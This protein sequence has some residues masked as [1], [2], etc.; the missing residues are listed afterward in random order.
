MRRQKHHIQD[1]SAEANLFARR[2][3]VAL[4]VV[5]ALMLVLIANMFYL[6]I[7][8]YQTYQTR[9]N[10]NRIKVQPVPPNRGVI[11][12]INGNILA[13]NE[14]TFSLEVIPEAVDDMDATLDSL[15][16]IIDI[17]DDQIEQ[18]KEVIKYQRRFKSIP[19]KTKLTEQEVAI[20]SVQQHRFPG[21]AIEARL[22]RTY[23]YSDVMTH[24]IG[25]VG[26]INKR[27]LN[28]LEQ[29]DKL[30]NYAA[31]RSIG[32]IGI[33]RFYEDELHGQTGNEEVEVNHRS[34]V[35]RQL[36]IEP[37]KPGNDLQLSI[38]I[39]MQQLAK[40]ALGKN[41]GAIVALDPRDGAI[42]TMYSNPSYD[43]NLFVSGISQKDYSA[44]TS[45]KDKPMLNRATQGQYPPAS[46]VKPQIALLGLEKKLV[47][48]TTT[49][50][51]PG[52]WRFP[53]VE[54][55]RAFRDWKPSGHGW[56]DL[57]HSLVQ[58]CDIYYYDLAYRLGIDEIS[59]FGKKF[60]FGE[61]TGIDIH[62]ESRAIMPSREWKKERTRSPW[63]R[64][65]TISIGIGQGYWTATPTQLA[66]AT[67]VLVNKGE[68]IEP[69]IVTG[70][71]IDG[72]YVN[73]PIKK[74]API[75]LSDPNYWDIILDGLY[76]TVNSPEGTA[77]TA[78]ADAVYTSAGKTGTAQLFSLAEDEEYDEEKVAER[79]RDNAMYVGFAPFEEP[80]IVIVVAVEN[81]G[82]GSSNAAP[83]ARKMM[84]LYFAL[85]LADKRKISDEVIDLTETGLSAA[86]TAILNAPGTLKP[87]KPI[88]T[89]STPTANQH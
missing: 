18:F 31:T 58:S 6:Q 28:R 76:A 60:G 78:F 84:D 4:I 22:T 48:P 47:T 80:T 1:H 40:K 79:K 88:A 43:P 50:W 42:L 70:K 30:S 12:D 65:D 45:S 85:G 75:E 66:M 67:S 3:I 24:V 10:E 81:A 37:P 26:K 55:Q 69:K 71:T 27:D 19:L 54:T 72:E 73:T 13:A 38:A 64:G 83:I 41:R 9:S 11:R 23:P 35:L 5:F 49:I 68:V 17:S 2:T 56:V 57:K 74:R 77:R 51:D 15:Q 20:F 34:R 59:P 14:P 46:T 7:E 29:N 8:R 62:E 25:Y 82:G 33:E 36:D 53:N 89:G 44:I 16:T 87:V 61:Y 52:Y 21:V 32:K 63:Y 39:E 86:E